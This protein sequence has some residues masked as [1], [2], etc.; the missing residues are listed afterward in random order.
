V[1]GLCSS[2]PADDLISI[3]SGFDVTVDD[4]DVMASDLRRLWTDIDFSDDQKNTLYRQLREV[5]PDGDKV[6]TQAASMLSHVLDGQ[7]LREVSFRKWNADKERILTNRKEGKT[8]LLFDR[9]MSRDGGSPESGVDLI[10]EVLTRT[11]SRFV[12]CLLSHTISADGEQ[13]AWEDL[14]DQLDGNRFIPISKSRLQD[15]K[16][17]I[18][19]L[20]GYDGSCLTH[21]S[22]DLRAS[23]QQ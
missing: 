18:G 13:K 22:N 21:S 14:S 11:R 19:L 15:D 7:V 16:S 17:L 2:C 5:V 9:D 6:D 23:S 12:C 10:R 20:M 8:L 4:A 1:I 3:L